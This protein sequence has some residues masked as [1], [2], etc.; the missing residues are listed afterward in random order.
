MKYEEFSRHAPAAQAALVTMGKVI[1]EAGLDK[2]LTELIKL[3]VSQING[4]AF[5]VQIHLNIA[6][7][8]NV[9]GP[10]LDLVAAWRD[11]GLFSDREKAAFAYAEA[12]TALT[13]H[14]GVAD[15]QAMIRTQF[16]ENEVLFLTIAIATIN[17]WNRLG[18]GLGFPPPIPAKAAQST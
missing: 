14:Q 5:C 10:K 12:L 8:L 7:R 17:T 18:V 6:R 3:R 16:S 15:A 1:D 2:E 9:A 13:D 11:A 4:C